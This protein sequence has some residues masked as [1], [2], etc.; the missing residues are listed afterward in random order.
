M[1]CEIIEM[2]HILRRT[3]LVFKQQILAFCLVLPILFS[4]A[5]GGGSSSSSS[6]PPGQGQAGVSIALNPPPSSTNITVGS[7]AGIQFT[8]VVSNDSV[9]YGIDWALTCQLTTPGACG[10]LSIPNFHSA[11]GTA[12]TYFPPA[13]LFSGTLTVNV[14]VFATADH[15]K[16]VTTPVTITSFSNVLN[17]TYVLQ[18][19]GSDSNTLPYQSTGI[20]VLDGNGNIISGQQTLNTA[21]GFSSTY[22]VQDQKAGASTY[23]IGSDG[24]GTM[25]LNLEQTSTG[26]PNPETFTFTV[27]STARAVV[28][29]LDSNSGSGTLELQDATAAQTMPSGAYAFVTNG[30]DAGDPN[31]P[32]GTPVPTAFGGILNIDN[33]PS[34]GS[35]SGNGS[36]ADQD[37]YN[38]PF[39]ARKLLSCVPPAGVTGSVS[40]PVAPGIVTISVTGATCF[41][42]PQPASI[43]FTGYIVDASHIRLIESD[44]LDGTSGFLTAGIAISQGSEAG[45]F[46]DASLSGP[47]VFGVLGYDVNSGVPSSFTSAGTV[48]ADGAG[49]V[50]GIDDTFFLGESTGFTDNI[51]TGT[52][53][54]DAGQIGRVGVLPKFKGAVPAPKVTLLLYLTGN[55]TPP[56]VL[57]SEGVDVNYPAVG[58]GVAYPQAANASTLS[59]GNPESYGFN[60]TQNNFGE[61]DASGKM[62]TTANGIIGTITGMIE[63]FNNNDFNGAGSIPLNDTFTIPAD[64]FGRVSGTFRNLSGSA[65][66]YFEYYMVDNSHGFL[67]ET[68]LLNSGQ[69]G[70]G[71]FEQACDV[72]NIASCQ[73]AASQS[74]ARTQG[75]SRRLR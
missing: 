30:T 27:L 68:D 10:T 41:G 9:D 14:T 67:E 2:V 38:K 20:F 16:N 44:D 70:L 72:T 58:T 57:W 37:Y 32:F 1:S 53:A 51:L 55:G 18:I 29:E 49:K 19:E 66:P 7:T 39:T 3:A 65:G 71:Y 54:T 5:C 28:A 48:V 21:F 23:F 36:L 33:N 73:A 69:V 22:T 26:T 25:T 15:T 45:T 47:Y 6:P 50:T 8:P 17:G 12:V 63:D 52:Y 31:G 60:L 35:I 43:R 24:R 13:T 11:S 59:F 61:F 42:Q 40:Q 64:S 46:T 74:A 75:R 4:L 62:S 56:L 34:T